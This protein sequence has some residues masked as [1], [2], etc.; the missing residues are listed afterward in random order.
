MLPWPLL[1]RWS[2]DRALE[3][4]NGSLDNALLGLDAKWN[5]LGHFSLYGQFVFDELKVEEFFKN[6]G[7]W[8]NKFSY[9]LGLKYIDVLNVS[10]LDLQLE[11]NWARPYTYTHSTIYS[12]YANYRQPVAHPLGANFREF[13]AVARYQP[14]PRLSLT[15]KLFAANY[16][17]DSAD[18]NYGKEILK[19]YTTRVSDE[20][21][22]G[23]CR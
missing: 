6:P 19:D 16:G 5:F 13:I 14:W 9:Q 20:G 12:N 18:T 21:K 2:L 7:W 17:L 8:G 11:Y 1:S 10:N 15:A 23:K 3:Q 22:A 4:Q